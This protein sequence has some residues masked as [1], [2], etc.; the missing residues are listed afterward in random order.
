MKSIIWV[1]KNVDNS[2][3]C[4]IIFK[5]TFLASCNSI[6][7]VLFILLL[8]FLLLIDIEHFSTPMR[9]CYWQTCKWK[10]SFPFSFLQHHAIYSPHSFDCFYSD[11]I[12]IHVPFLRK[13]NMLKDSKE[14]CVKIYEKGYFIKHLNYVLNEVLMF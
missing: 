12:I 1:W 4:I 13:R 5:T 3:K 14:P 9:L 8:S 7:H 2:I 10:V 11:F 6:W